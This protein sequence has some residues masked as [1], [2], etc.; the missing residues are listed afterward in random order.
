MY[1]LCSIEEIKRKWQAFFETY[2]VTEGSWIYQMYEVRG[3]WCAAYHAGNHY[4]GL[5]SNQRSES[6]NSR[7]QM[8]LDGKITLLE[9][10]QH[11]ESCLT[12]VHRIEA[13][14]DANVLQSEPFTD[15]DASILEVNAKKRFTPNVFKAKVQFSVEADKKC[16]LIEI[17]FCL[18]R[19]CDETDLSPVTVGGVQ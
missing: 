15:L 7:L 2:D 3:T 14:D 18:Y 6:M 4:L 19:F 17:L 9:M 16:S 8:K 11:Y 13:D 10:V 1:D 5:R 12:K